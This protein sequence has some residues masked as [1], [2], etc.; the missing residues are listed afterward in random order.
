MPLPGAD[1]LGLT[2]TAAAQDTIDI[3]TFYDE[4]SPYGQWVWH[5]RFGYVWLPENVSANWRPY[6]VGR[7]TYTDEYG[8]YSDS[9]E[10]FAWAVYPLR[11]LGL[12]SGL[13]LVLGAGRY[14][15][16]GVG[17]VAL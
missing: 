10:P 4:L 17:A 11:P 6:T 12:R 13:R 9:Y 15:G 8:W 3:D 1:R 5:P 14:L 2:G 7:W 16:A